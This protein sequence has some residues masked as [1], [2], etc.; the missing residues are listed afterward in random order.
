MKHISVSVAIE[1]GHSYRFEHIRVVV[2]R[3][4]RAF[5]EEVVYGRA[6]VIHFDALRQ[7]VRVDHAKRIHAAV[8]FK[9]F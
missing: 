3:P 9:Q 7:S 8:R 2:N 5:S 6:K 4:G 1:S